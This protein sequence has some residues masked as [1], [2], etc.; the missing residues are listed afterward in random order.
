M[1]SVYRN[2]AITYYDFFYLNFYYLK[3][4]LDIY[5]TKFFLFKLD[6]SQNIY[7]YNLYLSIFMFIFGCFRV[8]YLFLSLDIIDFL[9]L[10][11]YIDVLLHEFNT[12]FDSGPNGPSDLGLGSNGPEGSGSPGPESPRPHN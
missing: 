10:Y 5:R 2:Y 3:F 7:K 1:F 6:L 12:C 8:L 4:K 11:C 9:F